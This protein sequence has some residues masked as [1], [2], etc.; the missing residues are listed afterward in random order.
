[1]SVLTR[2]QWCRSFAT[3][4][5]AAATLGFGG[6]AK[7]TANEA[8]AVP[9]MQPYGAL[10]RDQRGA[11]DLPDG[12]SWRLISRMG[13]PM[14]DGFVVPGL[15]DGMACF[16]DRDG[17]WRLVRNHELNPSPHGPFGPGLKLRDQMPKDLLFDP[18]RSTGWPGCGGTTTVVIDPTTGAVER[19]FVSLAGTYRNCAGGPT[20]WGSWLS[21]E[22]TTIGPDT[23]P[24]GNA[25]AHGWV[26]EVPA[27]ANAPVAPQPL[28]AMGRFNHEATAI[29]PDGR[30]IYQSEDRG[31]GCIYRFVPPCQVSSPPAVSWRL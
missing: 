10:R 31:D 29:D 20:P 22:E 13:Q 1:M 7:L 23:H 30:I 21:C 27:E 15:P 3:G 24:F 19:E 17:K 5:A 18:G 6:L 11:I 12:F 8:A 9:L 25:H 26:F 14:S 28:R 16:T 4:A 2:R